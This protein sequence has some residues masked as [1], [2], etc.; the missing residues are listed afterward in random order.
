MQ[1]RRIA[2]QPPMS[3]RQ[4]KS[5]ITQDTPLLSDVVI[6]QF[7]AKKRIAPKIGKGGL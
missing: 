5:I 4:N 2:L 7:K 6:E 1:A 3:R